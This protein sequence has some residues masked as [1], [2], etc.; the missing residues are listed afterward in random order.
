MHTQPVIYAYIH[1]LELGLK[2]QEM[3]MTIVERHYTSALSAERH[4]IQQASTTIVKY[5][6]NRNM[7]PSTPPLLMVVLILHFASS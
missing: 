1:A 7:S 3:C 2:C 4:L 5:T 6:V